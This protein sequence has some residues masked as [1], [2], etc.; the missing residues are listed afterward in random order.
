LRLVPPYPIC[1]QT[2]TDKKLKLRQLKNRDKSGSSSLNM[3]KS[4]FKGK[5]H[6][7]DKKE[8]SHAF[9]SNCLRKG[10]GKWC[11]DCAIIV[12]TFYGCQC[13]RKANDLVDKMPDI[14]RTKK[15]KPTKEKS[16]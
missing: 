12:S 11:P 14:P 1:V 13:G 15:G 4:Q 2:S 3:P 8:K 10:H 9:S 5:H 6:C 16:A 7:P